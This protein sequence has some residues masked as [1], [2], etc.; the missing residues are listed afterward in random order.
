MS[1]VVADQHR[2]GVLESLEGSASVSEVDDLPRH[3]PQVRPMTADEAE[4]AAA[5]RYGGGCVAG[6][7]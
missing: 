2:R 5:W 1:V 3:E 4:L 6:R 7:G